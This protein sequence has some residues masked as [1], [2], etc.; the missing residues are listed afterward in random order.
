V[1]NPR[2]RVYKR[3]R[4]KASTL[5]NCAPSSWSWLCYMLII[6]PYPI[7]VEYLNY[8]PLTS[9]DSFLHHGQ[10]ACNKI[11][12]QINPDKF[13]IYEP[14]LVLVSTVNTI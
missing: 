13:Q 5:S 7:G 2:M 8:V 1:E 4:A 12:S 3:P 11:F 14:R 10:V 6:K 9:P